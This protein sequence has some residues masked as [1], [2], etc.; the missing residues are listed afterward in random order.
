MGLQ[1]GEVQQQVKSLEDA[2][3][4]DMKRAGEKLE[5]TDATL[6][7]LGSDLQK[8]SSAHEARCKSMEDGLLELKEKTHQRLEQVWEILQLKTKDLR[9]ELMAEITKLPS[10]TISTHGSSL[11][12]NAPTF[13][14]P[15][16]LELSSSAAAETGTATATDRHS[17][18]P[19]HA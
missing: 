15:L 8:L 4:Q 18:C 19:Y 5:A 17:G 11:S 12:P 3:A 10:P 13:V 14:P 9:R 7:A 1:L 2:H 16:D 6:E